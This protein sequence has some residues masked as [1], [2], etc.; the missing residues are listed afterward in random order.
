M[1]GFGLQINLGFPGLAL[2][3]PGNPFKDH[4]IFKI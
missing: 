4:Y 2:L 3:S 1:A